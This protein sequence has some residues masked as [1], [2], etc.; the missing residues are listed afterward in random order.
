M[1]GRYEE[2]LDDLGPPAFAVPLEDQELEALSG[3]LPS[4]LLDFLKTYGVGMWNKGKFQFCQPICFAPLVE[5]IFAGDKQLRPEET[6]VVGYSAFGE[7]LAW[8]ERFEQVL[9][10][11]PK[12]E[13][14]SDVIVD[15]QWAG[16]CHLTFELEL[17]TMME[18]AFDFIEQTDEADYLFD[19]ALARL[20]QLNLGECYGFVPALALGGRALLKNLERLD[21]LVH[22]S[23]LADLGPCQLVEGPTVDKPF[24]VVRTIGA[25]LLRDTR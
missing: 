7:L 1:S 3:K 22:F 19:R 4:D 9:I 16:K 25:S 23:I 10:S 14:R 12:L 20:G 5:R 17:L 13:V 6:H 21:A 18:G 24:T 11:L 8:N 15:S 2:L